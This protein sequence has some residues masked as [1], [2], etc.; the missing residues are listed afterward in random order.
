MRDYYGS[1]YTTENAQIF[2]I[3]TILPD[4]LIASEDERSA[5]LAARIG[6]G[7]VNAGKDAEKAI[8]TFR[9]SGGRGKPCY[10]EFSAAFAESEADGIRLAYERWSIPA[11]AGEMN[12][13]LPTPV[14]YEQLQTMIT[15]DDVGEKVV[16]GSNADRFIEK[17][18]K[19]ADMGFD[20]ICIHQVGD[21]QQGFIEFMQAEVM[22]SFTAG[23][24]AGAT[25]GV[26][27]G[28]MRDI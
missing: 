24:A 14:H 10:L 11:F 22:P 28:G 1:Y 20:H 5:M 9:D 17:I 27:G 8:Q 19:S 13:L 16:C 7:L 3:P 25:V 15:Q 26:A 6:D 4:I 12:R 23:T 18:E 21:D 2:D